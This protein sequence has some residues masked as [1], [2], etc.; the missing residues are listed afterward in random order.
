MVQPQIVG[1]IPAWNEAK[2]ISPIVEAAGEYLQVLVVD[3]GSSDQTAAMAEGAGAAVIRHPRNLG[4][5]EALKTGF[6][7][8]MDRECEAV[9]TLDAD[10]QHD[11]GEIPSFLEAHRQRR[12]DMIIGRRDWRKMPFPRR[13][14]NPFG[15]WLLS[16]LLGIPVYDSQSGYR[17]YTRRFLAAADLTGHGFDLETEA[18]IQA[19]VLGLSIGWIKIR[20]LYG[21][22][23]VSYFNPLL[24]TLGFFRMLG[25]A[26]LEKRRH[27]SGRL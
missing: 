12:G 6:N 18:I 10:G 11:P 9:L 26:V 8:A 16:K 5:G 25:H 4:K 24:D 20:T 19:A 22:G 2:Q 23:E 7:W 27:R 1:L 15:S 21:I 17:L 13:Y 3:D 14:T